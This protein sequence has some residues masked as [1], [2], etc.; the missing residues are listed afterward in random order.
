MIFQI[1]DIL[2]PAIVVQMR[3]ALQTEEESFSSG[4]ATAGWYARDVKHND[5]SSGPAAQMAMEQVKAA[6]LAHALFTSVARPKSFV[7]TL[8]S[9]YRPGMAYGSHVDNALMGGVRTDMSFTL[10]LSDP[11][12]YQGGELV[13]EG[14]D[15]DTSVKLPAGSLVIYP[16]TSL[17]HVTE[18]TTGE[19]LAV[20]GWVRS[21]IRSLEQRETLFE[22]DQIIEGLRGAGVERQK[23]DQVFKVRNTLTRIWV[24]D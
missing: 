6:L 13:I 16:T 8:V 19:R 14:H 15:G 9:R 10:F 23:T 18:V 1:T 24:E 3:D 5:Q 21:F 22:L 11:T 17:H 4:K 2:A 20:V 7:K 12:T